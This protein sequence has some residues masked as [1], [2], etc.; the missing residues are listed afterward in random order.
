MQIDQMDIRGSMLGFLASHPLRPLVSLHHWEAT[1]PIFPKMTPINALQHLFEAVR[2]DSQRIMQQTVCYDRWFS[3]TISVSWG[4]AVQIFPYH[5]FLPD[6]LRTQETFAPWK[7]GGGI[8][9]W[10][11]VDTLGYDPNPCRRPVV[12]Y[13]HNVSSGGDGI[14]S[15]YRMITSENC[16]SDVGSPRRIEEIRVLSHKQDLDYK[17]LQAPR[18]QCCDV[19][20]S[21]SGGNVME[22]AI[23]ECG[24]QE[25]IHMH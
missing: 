23:R 16:T 3:W 11:N 18:R 8:N 17:Q 10:Y 13:M 21:A 25:L 6:A 9:D 4:Y 22:I 5:V 19:L 12:F 15:N 2:L 20:P 14:R 1:D 24:D 7:R